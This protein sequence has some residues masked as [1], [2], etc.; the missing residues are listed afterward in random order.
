M[1]RI[2]AVMMVIGMLGSTSLA[3]AKP[4]PNEHHAKKCKSHCKK[5]KKQINH[6]HEGRAPGAGH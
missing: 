6:N 1:R 3:V 5:A 4:P 2:A